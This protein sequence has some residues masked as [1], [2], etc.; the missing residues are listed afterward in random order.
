MKFFPC[1]V[2][3]IGL[4]YSNPAL[5]AVLNLTN[6][7][8]AGNSPNTLVSTSNTT[9][10]GGFLNGALFRDPSVDGSAGSGVFRDLYRVS[11]PSGNG[12]VI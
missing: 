1:V 6:T 2:A 3:G 9:F 5:A 4:A 11:P 10:R 12:N 8:I 7:I